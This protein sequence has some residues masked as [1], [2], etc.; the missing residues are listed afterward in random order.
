MKIIR[1]VVFDIISNP[2]YHTEWTKKQEVI[3]KIEKISKNIE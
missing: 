2:S 3:D 1:F